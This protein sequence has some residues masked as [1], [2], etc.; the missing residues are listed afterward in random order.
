MVELKRERKAHK[1][2][3]ITTTDREEFHRQLPISHNDITDLVRQRIEE[4]I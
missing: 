4:A 3:L 1:V 2:W